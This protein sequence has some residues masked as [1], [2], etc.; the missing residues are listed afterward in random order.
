[1]KL[2]KTKEVLFKIDRNF[3]KG[4]L[5]GFYTCHFAYRGKAY[6]LTKINFFPPHSSSNKNIRT[7]IGSNGELLA[8]GGDL[9][10]ERMILAYKNGI[11][12]LN[13]D[14]QPFLWWT[15]EIRYVLFPRNIHITKRMRQFIRNKDFTLTVDK[16][17]RA[18]IS[19]CRESRED[20][21]WIT[22]ERIESSCELHELGFAHSVEVW[23]DGELVGGLFGV[24][25]GSYFHI[26]SLFKRVNNASKVAM[27]AFVLRLNEMKGSVVDCG[28][29]VSDHIK[30]MGAEIIS[31]DELLEIID[32]NANVSDVVENWTDLFENWDFK[33]AAENHFIN[34]QTSNHQLV[35]KE[36]VE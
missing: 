19:A 36:G 10:S 3:F 9:S 6:K 22:P 34:S 27:I 15:S 13:F 5:K 11:F 1:M 8:Y 25:F 2:N 23:Q 30:G 29:S 14:N 32:Q 21:T 16:A 20:L 35:K 28:F 33:A 18:V 4:N 17:F 24:A 31:R 26:E 12:P 7:G